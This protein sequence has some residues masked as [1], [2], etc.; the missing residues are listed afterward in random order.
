[1]LRTC[2]WFNVLACR[3]EFTCPHTIQFRTLSL[4]GTASDMASDSV[5]GRGTFDVDSLET[6]SN[7]EWGLTKF[8]CVIQ[9]D[10][11]YC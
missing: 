9:K 1:M 11:Y 10:I 2:R 3:N 7:G 8:R 4:T 5:R 6:K